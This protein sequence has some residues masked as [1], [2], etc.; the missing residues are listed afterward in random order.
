MWSHHLRHVGWPD[1]FPD[2]EELSAA[3]VSFP[4]SRPPSAAS[5]SH[6]PPMRLPH[7]FVG[8]SSTDL[9]YYRLMTAWKATRAHRL[10]LLRLP[11]PAK[12][13]LH[14][15]SLYPASAAGSG[16]TW[17][18]QIVDD[19]AG[20]SGESEPARSDSRGHGWKP[21]SVDSLEGCPPSPQAITERTTLPASQALPW[22]R[23]GPLCRGVSRAGSCP[24]CG[25][26]R[27]RSRRS[28]P[29]R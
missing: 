12:T 25:F 10:Q 28:C 3:G 9:H 5:A 20:E 22:Q 14:E 19:S 8:F 18:G 26:D 27:A 13:R 29:G 15:R 17:P 6:E 16:S 21:R 1:A 2:A 23:P 4:F 7:T 24:R 11:A